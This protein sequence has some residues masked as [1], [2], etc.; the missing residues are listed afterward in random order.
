MIV[1]CPSCTSRYRIRDE[2]VSGRGARITCPSCAH[3]FV[4]H[5]ND[6]PLVVGGG[7]DAGSARGVPV[8]FARGGE[9]LR[10]DFGDE[11]DEA[12]VPTTVM[13]HGSKL[14]QSIREAAALKAQAE[15]ANREPDA[16]S[17]VAS[18]PTDRARLEEATRA[19]RAKGKASPVAPA[20]APSRRPMVLAGLL[21]VALVVAGL[22]AAGMLPLPQMIAGG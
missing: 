1:S 3:K 22:V 18:P 13:P 19:L 10:N 21:V 14:V 16:D 15:A 11:D 12:D 6:E 8:T 5:R 7:A 2:K 9:T 20:E 4:V 17:P